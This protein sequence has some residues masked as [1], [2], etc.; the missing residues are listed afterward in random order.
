MAG[1]EPRPEMQFTYWDLHRKGMTQAQI[2]REFNITRQA[3]NKSLK[4]Y[5]RVMMYRL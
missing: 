2:A 1:P 5:E 4:L 3:V